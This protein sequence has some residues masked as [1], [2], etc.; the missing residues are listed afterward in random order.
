MGYLNVDDVIHYVTG[1]LLTRFSIIVFIV[2]SGLNTFKREQRIIKQYISIKHKKIHNL[3][4][5]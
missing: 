3:I 2:L 5:W 4:S 1:E